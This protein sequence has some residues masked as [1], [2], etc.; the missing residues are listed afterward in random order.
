MKS[1]DVSRIIDPVSQHIVLTGIPMPI[2]NNGGYSS[3]TSYSGSFSSW[4]FMNSKVMKDAR[5]IIKKWNNPIK[6]SLYFLFSKSNLI[7]KKNT[8]KKAEVTYKEE[9]V[10]SMLCKHLKVEQSRFIKLEIEKM[11]SA[12]E[13]E[14]LI[15]VL[16]PAKIR[17][18]LDI[19]SESEQSPLV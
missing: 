19:Y 9:V 13:S 11:L 16:E 18:I 10:I 2:S 7:S 4:V 17:S 3:Q 8:L 5:K 12:S 14:Q 6:V 15:V 1:L